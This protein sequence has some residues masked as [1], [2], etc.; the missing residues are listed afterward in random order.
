MLSRII[1]LPDTTNHSLVKL[2]F[3]FCNELKGEIFVIGGS[4][5]FNECCKEEFYT[6]LN[7]IYLTRFNDE[8]HPRDTTHSFPLKLLSNMKLVDRSHIQNEMCS[9]PHIDN[10]EKGFLQEYLSETYTKS[11]S[12]TFDIYQNSN[13]IN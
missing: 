6:D 2:A 7:K 5:I 8:Y 9:R 4:Q 10:R 13:D 12:F 3:E 1:L 11:V